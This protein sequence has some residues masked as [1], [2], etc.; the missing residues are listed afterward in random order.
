MAK[1]TPL[2]DRVVVEFD[3]KAEETTTSSGF[4]V[5][6]KE[7]NDRPKS[8]KVVSVGPD[9]KDVSIGDIIIF[10]EFIPTEFKHEEN[11]YLILSQE[12]ILAKIV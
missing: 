5:A 6:S 4:I 8:G 3:K 11:E 9:V 1:I 12:D 2:G 10:K 7:K